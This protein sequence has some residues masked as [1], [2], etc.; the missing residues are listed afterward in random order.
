MLQASNEDAFDTMER[1]RFAVFA[2]STI[3][4]HYN[5]FCLFE[6]R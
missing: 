4:S 5:A 6:A 3:R 1:R 2:S